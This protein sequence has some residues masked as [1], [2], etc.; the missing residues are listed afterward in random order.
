MR[1]GKVAPRPGLEPGTSAL[2]VRRIYQLSY[3]GKKLKSAS[4]IAQ[5]LTIR[6]SRARADRCRAAR[7]AHERVRRLGGAGQSSW[8]RP[9]ITARR[10]GLRGLVEVRTAVRL[11]G[12]RRLVVSRMVISNQVSRECQMIPGDRHSRRSVLVTCITWVANNWRPADQS[13]AHLPLRRRLLY[14]FELAGQA[15]CW[16]RGWDS[17]P[18]GAMLAGLANRCLRPLGYLVE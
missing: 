12:R 17:N 15:T 8:P 3:R 2:T 14:P 10:T 7:S 18:Y 4:V 9:W 16:K 11:A 5:L 13:K 1:L 6:R